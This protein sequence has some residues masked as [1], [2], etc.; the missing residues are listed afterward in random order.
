MIVMLLELTAEGT[1][2]LTEYS[3]LVVPVL[4]SIAF[5]P[6]ALLFSF[7]VRISTVTER[8]VAT[9]PFTTPTQEQ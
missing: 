4:V 8:T 2:P 9:I 1:T 6:L 7:I 5:V 3:G